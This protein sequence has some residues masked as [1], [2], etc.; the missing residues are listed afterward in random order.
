MEKNNI[1]RRKVEL[2]KSFN[3]VWETLC[4]KSVE[5]ETEVRTS[6]VVK[7]RMA[8]RLGFSNLEKVLLFLKNDG[9]GNLKECSR[10]Y[11]DD[12]GYYFNHLG[13]EGQRIGMYC[14]ALDS[15]QA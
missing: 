11:V 9:D 1:Q 14:K 5:L 10:C 4:G 6:F 8:K 15:L 2:T 12:W 7:A 3:D 13:R